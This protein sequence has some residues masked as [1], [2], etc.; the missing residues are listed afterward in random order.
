ML[1]KIVKNHVGQ[2]AILLIVTTFLCAC[3]GQSIGLKTEFKQANMEIGKTSKSDIVQYFGLPQ[4]VLKD[5]SGRDH[6]FY[7]G[8][9]RLVGLCVGCGDV[10]Q[11]PGLIPSLINQGIV[12]EGAE[13][14]FDPSGILVA[15]FESK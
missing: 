12:S 11:G 5:D 13:Y 1:G 2:F 6:F 4:K 15:K 9:T 3:G 8:A 10:N 7:E 14:V